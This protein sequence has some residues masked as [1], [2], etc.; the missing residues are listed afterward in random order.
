MLT[1]NR[2]RYDKGVGLHRITVED[3]FKWGREPW[4]KGRIIG[5]SSETLRDIYH[6][7]FALGSMLQAAEAAWVQGQDEYSVQNYALAAAMELHARFIN[8]GMAKS[9]AELP[10]GF[11]F[12]ENMPPAP[13]NCSAWRW[14]MESQEWSSYQL[15]PPIAAA[16]VNGT[17]PGCLS[18]NGT[19]GAFNGTDA[20]LN[21]T[22]AS[23]NGT[24]AACGD[25]AV[26]VAAV[27]DQVTGFSSDA[28]LNG[29]GSPLNGT[30]AAP[31]GTDNG[32]APNGTDPSLVINGTTVLLVKSTGLVNETGILLNGTDISVVKVAAADAGLAALELP[33]DAVAAAAGGAAAALGAANATAANATAAAANATAAPSYLSAGTDLPY[34][35]RRR[36]L[37]SGGP[38]ADAGAGAP[39][40]AAAV[41]DP[42]ATS[43]VMSLAMEV[44]SDAPASAGAATGP[45]ELNGTSAAVAAP[46][47]AGAGLLNAT[48]LALGGNFTDG[49]LNATDASAT[50]AGNFTDGAL[51]NGTDANA[52]LAG[53]FTDGALNGTGFN[54]TL[55][56]LTGNSTDGLISAAAAPPA[57]CATLDDGFKYLVGIKYLPTG[58]E[59][60]YNHFVGR[61]GMKMPE[62]ALLLSKYPVDWW[63]A[64]FVC[65]H[66]CIY[67]YIYLYIFVYIYM[68]Y[69]YTY[70]YAH[71]HISS[72]THVYVCAWERAGLSRAL[73][74]GGGPLVG[75]RL[76]AWACGVSSRTCTAAKADSACAKLPPQVRVLL[77]PRHPDARQQRGAALAARRQARRAVQARDP[78]GE[79]RGQGRAAQEDA[80]AVQVPEEALVTHRRRTGDAPVTQTAAAS[81]PCQTC[82]PRRAAARPRATRGRLPG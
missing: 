82:Q 69:I 55:G 58:W 18:G 24:G 9:E 78:K 72:Y 30:S 67:I 54:F 13:D 1:N 43:G 64:R 41:L 35:A 28:P 61:L 44:P 57:K 33:A 49:A 56:N 47:A 22:D 5:E 80:A 34:S 63:A 8:A 15:P 31:N 7:Q 48:A 75:F 11:K 23:L 65:S 46:A 52:T 17:D 73:A 40:P 10:A 20:S 25:A 19:D 53:N 59:L 26:R 27:D 39:A 45:A 21:G 3:Y 37:Q 36:L 70:I 2:T 51:T 74:Q 38:V 60:G 16:S 32:L 77:G 14:D 68:Q 29:T 79:P 4:A 66:I 42:T 81:A 71:L 12:F 6:T 50:L 62:T 76:T